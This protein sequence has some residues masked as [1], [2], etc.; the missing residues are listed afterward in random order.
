MY[1]NSSFL[2]TSMSVGVVGVEAGDQ[3]L[4]NLRLSL[5]G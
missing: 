5:L 4:W 2:F 1:S 3:G